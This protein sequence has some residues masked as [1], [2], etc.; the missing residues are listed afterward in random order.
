MGPD[1][2]ISVT[3]DLVRR[4]GSANAALVWARI[5][6][7]CRISGRDRVED[8][9][10]TWW[11]VSKPKLAQDIGLSER[12]VRTTLENLIRDGHV[13]AKMVDASAWDR[14]LAY[15]AI[16][17]LSAGR[18]H[19]TE[20]SDASDEKGRCIGPNRPIDQ[21]KKADV[22]YI[23]E[24][25]NTPVAN[26]RADVLELCTLLQTRMVENGCRKPTISDRW[27]NDMRLLLDKDQVPF[28]VAKVVLEWSQQDSFWKPNIHSPSKFRIQFDALKLRMT[29][30]GYQLPKTE[31]DVVEW[32]RECWKK[33]DTKSVE[34]STGL[35][36]KPGDE[37][38]G[39]DEPITDF[40]RRMRQKWIDD[41]RPEIIR[42]MTAKNASAA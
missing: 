16:G 28:D 11:V 24:V 36:Y 22:P 30:L 25:K 29:E 17:R 8:E 1:E 9:D 7:V 5:E 31:Q 39:E 27:R 34:E 33:A 19:Q 4:L 42:R 23:E 18:T 3:A 15:R 26:D 6:F 20:K 41:N 14:S 32:L 38:P 40:N 13:E 37:S 2:F 35:H 12:T 10:G 21:T